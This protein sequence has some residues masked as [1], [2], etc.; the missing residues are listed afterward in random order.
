MIRRELGLF[1]LNVGGPEA[2]GASVTS[3]D[4]GDA[5]GQG[6]PKGPLLLEKVASFG[7]LEEVD[8]IPRGQAGEEG[9]RAGG[10][11]EA[12]GGVVGRA[13][14]AAGS[15][16]EQD[17]L[18]R[19]E[20]GRQRGVGRAIVGACGGHGGGCGGEDQNTPW[21]IATTVVLYSLYFAVHG[22]TTD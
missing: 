7:G 6:G 17:G 19:E 20:G 11:E 4:E 9:R 10:D 14:A 15:D 1:G 16:R 2:G 22:Q 21:L 12:R 5:V 8:G 3:G 13:H 18:P